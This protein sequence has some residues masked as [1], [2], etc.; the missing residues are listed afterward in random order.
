MSM[1]FWGLSIG[2]TLTNEE[3]CYAEPCSHQQGENKVSKFADDTK[4]C[5]AVEM[6]EGK[7]AIQRDLVS[8]E[9]WASANL[10]KFNKSQCKVLHLTQGNH[11][12]KYRLG[13]ERI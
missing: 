10:I 12:H 2:K 9:R 13:R 5:R 1:S 3:S 7:D 4:M 6:L 11:K 8:F